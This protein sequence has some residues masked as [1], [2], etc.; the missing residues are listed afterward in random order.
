MSLTKH[1]LRT[2]E[3]NA[4]HYR[5]VVANDEKGEPVEGPVWRFTTGK[6]QIEWQQCL[7][8]NDNRRFSIQKTSDD[9]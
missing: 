8:G 1:Q 5:K 7:G 3:H 4:V 6:L 2:P 9:G